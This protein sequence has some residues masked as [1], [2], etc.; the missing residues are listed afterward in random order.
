MSS[1]V[2]MGKKAMKVLFFWLFLVMRAQLPPLFVFPTYI[3]WE[4]PSNKALVCQSNV[5][6][7]SGKAA[8]LVPG[9]EC[10]SLSIVAPSD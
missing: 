2:A 5:T 10:N 4:S 8:L 7:L 3:Q 9:Y 6:A 1:T